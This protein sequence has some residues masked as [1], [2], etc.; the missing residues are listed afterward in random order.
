MNQVSVPKHA[1]PNRFR[2]HFYRTNS[3]GLRIPNFLQFNFI[4]TDS[5]PQDP[6][7]NNARKTWDSLGDANAE[8]SPGKG[9]PGIIRGIPL[10]Q[11]GQTYSNETI[12]SINSSSV[13][14][15][16]DVWDKQQQR[17]NE[18]DLDIVEWSV[19]ITS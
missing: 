14:P 6:N 1:G 12:V 18:P 17:V 9:I 5:F 16:G 3:A 19:K 7:D 11:T 15:E 8:P 10:T 4:N 2:D 13:E